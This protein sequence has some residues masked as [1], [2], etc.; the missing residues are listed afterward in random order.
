MSERVGRN[1]GVNYFTGMALALLSAAAMAAERIVLVS[2]M[3]IV[4]A[5]FNSL[6]ENTFLILSAFDIGV[7]TY[8]MNYLLSAVNGSDEDEIRSSLRTVSHYCRLSALLILAL[9]LAVSL[10]MPLLSGERSWKVTLF[11]LVYLPGQLG[12]YLFGS[13]VLLLSS[14]ERNYVVSVFVQTGRIVQE[15][16]LIFII[17][18]TENYLL[19]V[20]AVSIVTFVTY[21][22]IYL[23][24][25]HD[26]P[27]LC[28]K[29]GRREYGSLPG[30]SILAMSFHRS[31]HVFYRSLESVLVSVLFGS[32]VAGLYSNY[33]L[34]TSAFLTP[35]WVYESTVTPT[36][37]LRYLRGTRE[38]NLAL[39]KKNVC[40]NFILSLLA[41]LLALSLYTPYITLA[42]GAEYLLGSGYDAVFAFL[43]FLSSFRTTALV[44]RDAAGIYSR[45]W[46][47]ALLEVLAALLLSLVLS[48]LM[49]LIGIPVAFTASYILVVLWRENRTVLQ[50]ALYEEKWDFCAEEAALMA[51]GMITIVAVWYVTEDNLSLLR[52]PSALG[53]W[54]AAVSLWLLV[55]PSARRAILGRKTG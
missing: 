55:S 24:A 54:A 39:Y 16:L 28:R 22:A 44:F 34:V 27:L 10:L 21:L 3:N 11:F 9:G 40:F 4:Y 19:Y 14:K 6:Y 35:F 45:D 15:L 20:S 43:V 17:I 49:G 12:Q 7:T 47:K 1:A 29:G 48:P 38:E 18:R 33:L 25:G 2:R 51:Y 37:T 31:S 5:G 52:L 23:K 41:A 32:A 53:L 42:F 50:G 13:R 8:L 46:K 26:Y 36:I 30:R